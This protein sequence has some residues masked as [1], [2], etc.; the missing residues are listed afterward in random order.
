MKQGALLLVAA[1]AGAAG[2]AGMYQEWYIP[3]SKA[4]FIIIVGLAIFYAAAALQ[5]T[6]NKYRTSLLL[7]ALSL[8][9]VQAAGA[10]IYEIWTFEAILSAVGMMKISL[11]VLGTCALGLNV[12]HFT[13]QAAKKKRSTQRR[14]ESGRKGSIVQMFKRNQA[15]KTVA[16]V[17]GESVKAGRD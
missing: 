7:L 3:P 12:V 14:A 5:H 17:L 11:I 15:E 4:L 2:I 9:L 10:W 1:T 13:S 16:I 8:F 6:G